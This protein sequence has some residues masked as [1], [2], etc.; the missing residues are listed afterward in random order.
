VDDVVP[1]PGQPAQGGHA[2][3]VEPGQAADVETAW[4][5][6]P[7]QAGTVDLVDAG[8]APDDHV[9]VDPLSGEPPGEIVQV[10]LTTAPDR[11][12]AERVDEGQARHDGA[13][14]KGVRPA[15]SSSRYHSMV[16]ARPS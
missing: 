15:A 10:A 2:E 11:R 1:V 16:L 12:P 7:H 3:R 4:V 8:P 13:S 5:T 14:A 6:Q 9:D